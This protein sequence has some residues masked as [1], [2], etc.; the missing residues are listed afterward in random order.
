MKSG[1]QDVDVDYVRLNDGRMVPLYEYQQ[2]QQSQIADS[3]GQLPSNDYVDGIHGGEIDI[4]MDWQP[5][6]G[7]VPLDDGM[8]LP[9]PEP[10]GPT[11]PQPEL[12][13]PP[14]PQPELVGPPKP[15][16]GLVGKPG[17]TIVGPK[18]AEQKGQWEQNVQSGGLLGQ[19]NSA[20]GEFKPYPGQGKSGVNVNVAGSA[21][22]PPQGYRNVFD[23]AGNL[24]R[25][26][27]IPGGPAAQEEEAKKAQE[28]TSKAQA[29]E[30]A[31]AVLADLDRFV[32]ATERMSN[33]PLASV[34]RKQMAAMGFEQ[35]AEVENML[36][37]I[38]ANL[39]FDMIKQLKAA[40]P[41]GSTGLGAV[42]QIE[43]D[44]LG[45]ALGQ[46]SQVGDPDVQRERAL[47]LRNK[48][49]DTIHGDKKHRDNLLE[50]GKVT[51]QQYDA[52]QSLY[53]GPKSSLSISNA[54]R[55]ARIEELRSKYLPQ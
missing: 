35:Q 21:P 18:N 49:L 55:Q 43:F 46:L 24:V 40:S 10:V 4:D 14:K 41:T 31:T 34:A 1:D 27:V 30:S 20:T 39:R 36:T 42:T 45:A 9:P 16:S 22:A 5:M 51:R 12:V 52:I 3:I 32:S 50:E 25:Q 44:A 37:T 38:K 7:D 11:N 13:G 48:F 23:D 53:S 26:E 33:L 2:M 47:A 17:V 28:E 8:V 15:E 19:Q 6:P 29:L 54:D